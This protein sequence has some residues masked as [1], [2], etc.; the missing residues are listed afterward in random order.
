MVRVQYIVL[1]TYTEDVSAEVGRWTP[2]M[3]YLVVVLWASE[4]LHP[5]NIAFW[6]QGLSYGQCRHIVYETIHIV[7][8]II[9]SYCLD[10]MQGEVALSV[11][12]ARY[13]QGIHMQLGFPAIK[14]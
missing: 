13:S 5:D 10:Q 1:V 9:I 3:F 14:R 7:Y 8:E 12:L 6:I 4:N 2:T 11:D